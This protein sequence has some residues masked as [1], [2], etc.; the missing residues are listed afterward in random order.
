MVRQLGVLTKGWDD[1]WEQVAELLV[2]P[3]NV[4]GQVEWPRVDL[5]TVCDLQE[6]GSSIGPS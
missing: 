6:Q 3:A 1:C 4:V 2:H 5:R